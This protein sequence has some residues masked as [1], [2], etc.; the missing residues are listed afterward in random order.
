MGE[1]KKDFFFFFFC[2]IH[3]KKNRKKEKKERRKEG[4]TDSRKETAAFRASGGEFQSRAVAIAR[5]T[6]LADK[7]FASSIS[8]YCVQSTARVIYHCEY[9]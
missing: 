2:P 8:G 5:A 9:F 6:L 4:S 7:E 3:A 1:A